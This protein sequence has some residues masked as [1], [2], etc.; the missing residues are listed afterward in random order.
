MHFFSV[1]NLIRELKKKNLFS[2]PGKSQKHVICGLDE[3]NKIFKSQGKIMDI[4][5]MSKMSLI[6]LSSE[7]L[8]LLCERNPFKMIFKILTQ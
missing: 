2:K 5:T 3:I 4:T 1:E 8:K 7:Y 6:M